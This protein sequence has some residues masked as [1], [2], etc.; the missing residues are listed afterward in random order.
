MPA[1]VGQAHGPPG[2]WRPSVRRSWPG[3][4]PLW[5]PGL[6][7][8]GVSGAGGKPCCQPRR[9]KKILL[10]SPALSQ[11]GTGSQGRGGGRGG[12]Y[13]SAP[14]TGNFRKM[15]VGAWRMA[16]VAEAGGPGPQTHHQKKKR[17]GLDGGEGREDATV[18]DH[19]AASLR[20]PGAPAQPQPG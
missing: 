16:D 12:R 8:P 20:M 2:F 1:S 6:G 11:S 14:P 15:L 13:S 4:W 7:L 10:L 5:H 19:S 17:W 3:P 18:P 9:T